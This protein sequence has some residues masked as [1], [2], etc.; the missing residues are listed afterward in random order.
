M[1]AATSAQ[2]VARSRRPQHTHDDDPATQRLIS[3]VNSTAGIYRVQVDSQE[4]QLLYGS[5]KQAGAAV[6]NSGGTTLASSEGAT[7]AAAAGNIK[8]VGAESAAAP[9]AATG[10]RNAFI[11][12]GSGKV[13]Y[14][15]RF[16]NLLQYMNEGR[17]PSIEINSDNDR[18][19]K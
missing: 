7:S 6:A 8:V 12:E 1:A 11:G 10:P 16:P 17:V 19:A 15:T 18:L 14:Q 2:P 4:G 13:F 3:R 5:R 9:T